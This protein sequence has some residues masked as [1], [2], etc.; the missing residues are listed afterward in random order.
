MEQR[1][2]RFR[3]ALDQALM[4]RGSRDFAD[5]DEYRTYLIKLFEQL[6]SGRKPRLREE[7]ERLGPLPD[8]RL[9]TA[10]RVRA[11]MN[12]GSLVA[13]E[14]NSYSVNSHRSKVHSR[15]I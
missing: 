11:R 1:H 9:D 5:L 14:R 7:M 3:R 6:N 8:R 4:L 13:V 15:R 2:Y 10:K 12:S